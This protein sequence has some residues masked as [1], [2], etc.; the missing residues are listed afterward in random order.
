[1]SNI[2]LHDKSFRPFIDYGKIEEAIDKVAAKINDDYKD[3]VD[4]PVFFFV[5]NGSILFT[6]ELMK[7]LTFKC[8]I[9]CIKLSSYVGTR[10][11]GEVRDII[12]MTGSVKGKKVIIIEDIVDSG[13]TLSYLLKLLK[14]RK[15]K[16]LK[17]CTLLD[18]PSRR[19]VDVDVAYV[20]FQIPDKFVVGFG[21]DYEGKPL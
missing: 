20:D 3:S 12:G 10:S 19:V 16:N 9:V 18:K 1:M 5:L 15:P 6:A 14:E 11:T 2:R 21:L 7:R 4:P 17:L 13:R 8:E